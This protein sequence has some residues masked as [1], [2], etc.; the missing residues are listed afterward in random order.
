MFVHL[1]LRKI[2]MTWDWLRSW[3]FAWLDFINIHDSAYPRLQLSIIMVS[4]HCEQP[5]NEDK[6]STA[7]TIY[8]TFFIQTVSY[9]LG[10]WLPEDK[11]LRVCQKKNL[12]LI[13][14]LDKLSHCFVGKPDCENFHKLK[15]RKCLAGLF[16]WHR[17]LLRSV[18]HN[19]A[20]KYIDFS[21]KGNISPTLVI[22]FI[23]CWREAGNWWRLLS[24]GGETSFRLM[25]EKFHR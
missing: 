20:Q 3:E 11:L 13:H 8:N 10:G 16:C 5:V 6:M 15:R 12:T 17:H 19:F 25:D 21:L 14:S 24:I 22:W 18:S 2:F 4:G 7:V 9:F 1:V 23:V